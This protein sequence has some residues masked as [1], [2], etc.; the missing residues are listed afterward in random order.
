MQY[1]KVKI[2]KHGTKRKTYKVT[3]DGSVNI[4]VQ[5]AGQWE[6]EKTKK[7]NECNTKIPPVKTKTLA[8]FSCG[9]LLY[10]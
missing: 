10:L 2:K 4:Q 1:E 8:N 9:T 3:T 6:R 7:H 5:V